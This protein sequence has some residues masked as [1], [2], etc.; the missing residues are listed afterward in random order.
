MNTQLWILSLIVVTLLLVPMVDAKF[1][2]T[3]DDSKKASVILE[4]VPADM[5][6]KIAVAGG[7]NSYSVSR[8]QEYIAISKAETKGKHT[9]TKLTIDKSVLDTLY[10]Y[11]GKEFRFVRVVDGCVS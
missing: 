6:G 7:D 9:K 4:N 3:V 11:N 10:G 1:G 2:N 8:E 5:R